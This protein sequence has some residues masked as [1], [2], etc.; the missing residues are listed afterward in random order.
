MGVLALPPLTGD[1]TLLIQLPN[2]VGKGL[3]MRLQTFDVRDKERFAHCTLG[4][5]TLGRL[6]RIWLELDLACPLTGRNWSAR[7]S[8]PGVEKQIWESAH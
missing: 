2:R 6:W 7:M 1:Q 3:V 5:I 8:D 4:N